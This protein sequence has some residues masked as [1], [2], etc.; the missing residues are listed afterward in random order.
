VCYF[1]FVGFWMVVFGASEW[2]FFSRV[3]SKDAGLRFVYSGSSNGAAGFGH[4]ATVG[5]GGVGLAGEKERLLSDSERFL[6]A[7]ATDFKE[8]KV[9]KE[10]G[11]LKTFT[12]ERIEQELQN[13]YFLFFLPCQC[14]L[15]KLF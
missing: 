5:D 3:R 10:N 15:M 13:G 7:G 6:V 12:W 4:V 8:L 14:L 2:F 11:A 1:F 9:A